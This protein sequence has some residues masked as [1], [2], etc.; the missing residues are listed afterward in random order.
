M[1]LIALTGWL[2][3]RERE[4]LAFLIEENRILPHQL[5]GRRLRLT[6]DDRR[7]LA[8]RADRVGRAALRQLATIATPDALLHFPTRGED[9]MR[10]TVLARG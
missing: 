6:D 5:G 7:R 8:A 3:G 1:V 10:R 4:A 9:V 2:D